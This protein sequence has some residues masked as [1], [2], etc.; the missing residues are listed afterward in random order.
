MQHRVGHPAVRVGHRL[1]EEHRV[2][3]GEHGQ[4]GV[5]VRLVGEL[6]RA[7]PAPLLQ[8]VGD[9]HGQ[10]RAE[11]AERDIRHDVHAQAGHPGDPGI[12]DAGVVGAAFPA[13]VG[14][15]DD[16]GPPDTDRNPVLQDDLGEADPG[17]VAV[18]DDAGQQE[19][20]PV[21]RAPAAGVEHPHRLE[22]VAGLGCHDDA[23]PGEGV[24]NGALLV[25]ADQPFTPEPSSEE[26]KCFWKATKSATAGAART[27]EPARI[28]P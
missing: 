24:R 10:P 6:H 25:Q 22:R 21:G 5:E 16:S 17:D 4:V 23:Q 9:G 13:L 28:A 15:Q 1:G 19:Q 7:E 27:T 8:V 18:G 14:G 3:V 2:L 20:P 12:L 26:V 11:R